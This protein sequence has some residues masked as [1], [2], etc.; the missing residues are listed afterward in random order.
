M[1]EKKK[2]KKGNNATSMIKDTRRWDVHNGSAC[3]PFSGIQFIGLLYTLDRRRES[4]KRKEFRT[5][6][7]NQYSTGWKP[8][9]AIRHSRTSRQEFICDTR[10]HWSAPL[11]SRSNWSDRTIE[12]YGGSGLWKPLVS[13]STI[14]LSRTT[15]SDLISYSSNWSDKAYKHDWV[16]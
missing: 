4:T 14:K 8:G 6:Y 2:K 5:A 7:R 16:W 13:Q 1:I 9:S 11:S 15:G 3:L 12:S 10:F